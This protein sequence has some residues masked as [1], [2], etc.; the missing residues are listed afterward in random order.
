LRFY[1]ALH[2]WAGVLLR[3]GGICYFEINERFGSEVAALFG[4]D[5][6]VLQDINGC[7]RFVKYI[8]KV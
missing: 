2:S 1:K 5:S 8:H 7:N 6:V 4:P 3:E